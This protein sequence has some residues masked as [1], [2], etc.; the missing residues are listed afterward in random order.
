[1]GD[2]DGGQAQLL[3]DAADLLAQ[4]FANPRIQ[5]RQR[6]VE[7]Q[8]AR[9]GDQRTSQGYALALAAGQLLR[10]TAGEVIQLDQLQHFLDPL[11]GFAAF[12]LLHAQAKSDVLLHGHI[13][14]QRVALEYHADAAFLR[15]YGHQVLTVEQ[16]L[17]AIHPG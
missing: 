2:E 4:V 17:P 10:V 14:E 15:G 8:Q 5:R 13:G 11:F 9:A 3:L 16:N 12:D 1:M 7:Q 6:L